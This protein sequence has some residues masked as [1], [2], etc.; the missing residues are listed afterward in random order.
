MLGNKLG[1]SD[2]LQLVQIAGMCNVRKLNLA[3][4]SLFHGMRAKDLNNFVQKAGESGIRSMN[5]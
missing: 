4:N 5:V 2:F 3:V 1:K